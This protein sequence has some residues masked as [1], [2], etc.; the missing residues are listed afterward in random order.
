MNRLKIYSY[1]V[2]GLKNPVKRKKILTQLKRLNCS[3][4]FIQETHLGD[5]EHRKLQRDWVK[6]VYHS[7]YGKRRG[8]AILVKKGITLVTEKIIQDIKGRYVMMV[9]Q[10]NGICISLLNIYAPNEENDGFFE[11]VENLIIQEGKGILVIG[12]DFNTIQNGKLDRLPSE[13]GPISKRSKILNNLIKDS[14]LIDTWR[15]K[16]QTEKEFTFYSNPHNSYSRID[17]ILISKQDAYK[18]TNSGIEPITI[19]DL[20]TRQ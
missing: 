18:V 20:Y 15:M 2:H 5:E 4:A 12:G 10:I 1:N 19:S 3:I 6:E 13:K 7:S 11:T 17:F 14:G 9:G 16:H 8:V